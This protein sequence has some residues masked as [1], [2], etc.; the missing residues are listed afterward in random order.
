M[1]T[2][3]EEQ[4]LEIRRVI[5]APRNFV[6]QAWTDPAQLRKWFGPERVQTLELRADVRVGG[7]YRWELTNPEGEK[8]TCA[9]EYRELV[10]DSKIVFTWQWQDD[11]DWENVI[12]VVT[13]ELK[14]A[15][16]GTELRLR[17]ERFPNQTSREN[18]SQGWES[19]LDRL[20]NFCAN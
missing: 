15:K 14:D 4:V 6:Y 11:G 3:T 8:M 5:K 13:V 16:D 1:T 12:S 7:K 9:G 17:H 18:H 19:V 10:P 2:K 20:E